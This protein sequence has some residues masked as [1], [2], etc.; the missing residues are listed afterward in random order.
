MLYDAMMYA[1]VL[2]ATMLYVAM[3]PAAVLPAVMLYVA[4]MPAAVLPATM[5]YV[6]MM[7]ATIRVGRR[8]SS[9]VFI[10]EYKYIC[11]FI[12]VFKYYF[13]SLNTMYLNK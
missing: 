4:M 10:C 7:P 5:L 6:A 13:M 1:A 8:L 12:N 3:M 2:P 9:Y 11:V